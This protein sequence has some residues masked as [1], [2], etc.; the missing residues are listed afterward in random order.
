[1]GMVEA[2]AGAVQVSAERGA[3]MVI[4]GAIKEAAG[5]DGGARSC[6][7]FFVWSKK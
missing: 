7:L 1:M 5:H 3:T 4:F 2:P 6:M